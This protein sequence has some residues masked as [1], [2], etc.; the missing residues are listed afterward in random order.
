MNPPGIDQDRNPRALITDGR[1][2]WDPAAP[3]NEQR[4]GAAMAAA[5]AELRATGGRV[6]RSRRRRRAI[7]VI[8]IA[9]A[10]AMACGALAGAAAASVLGLYLW[11]V[12]P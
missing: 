6:Y 10:C 7:R 2:D 9:M 11:A 8:A 3:I 5:L 4:D 1:W 12:L